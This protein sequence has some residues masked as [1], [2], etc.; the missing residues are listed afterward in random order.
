MDIIKGL[1]NGTEELT[2]DGQQKF[3]DSQSI[4]IASNFMTFHFIWQFCAFNTTE[5]SVTKY[6]ETSL[7]IS[8]VIVSFLPKFYRSFTEVWVI[9][10][11]LD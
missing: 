4:Y 2:M 6:R 9:Q 1:I 3:L 5:D 7:V 11:Q 10:L 8:V